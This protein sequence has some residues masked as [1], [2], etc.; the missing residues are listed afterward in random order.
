[1]FSF[2][3]P[4][5]APLSVKHQHSVAAPCVLT[6]RSKECCAVFLPLSIGRRLSWRSPSLVWEHSCKLT[7]PVRVQVTEVFLKDDGQRS[8][9]MQLPKR[10]QDD[11]LGQLVCWAGFGFCCC[12][13]S[14]ALKTRPRLKALRLPRALSPAEDPEPP[15]GLSGFDTDMC[16]A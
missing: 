11:L 12:L 4:G 13:G 2:P 3:N 1:M 14:A 15:R 6:R 5:S 16:D 10:A 7:V 8:G 9:R